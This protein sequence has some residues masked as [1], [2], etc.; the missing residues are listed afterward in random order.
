[1]GRGETLANDILTDEQHRKLAAQLFNETWTY[2]EMAARSAEDNIQMERIAMASLYHWSLV[3]GPSQLFNGQWILGRVY[4]T[5]NLPAEALRHSKNAHQICLDSGLQDWYIASAQE[6]LA[7]A[8]ALNGQLEEAGRLRDAAKLSL[9]SVA[10]EEDRNH[11][12]SQIAEGP[13]FGLEAESY[14]L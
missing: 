12:A 9:E 7:R 5:L 4:V 3:G 14:H 8:L 10:D 2:L 1:M 13:W 6:G 11:I